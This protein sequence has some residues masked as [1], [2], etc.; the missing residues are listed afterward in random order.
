MKKIE[1][2]GIF[3]VALI[4]TCCF[5][6]NSQALLPTYSDNVLTSSEHI[7]YV[8]TN[9]ETE[10]LEA[11]LESGT[12][13]G[14]SKKVKHF[15]EN[16]PWGIGM[17]LTAMSVVFVGLLLL[18]VIFKQV[19]KTAVSISRRKAVKASGGDRSSGSGELVSGAVVAAI[20]AAL[21]EM[22]EDVHDWENTVLTI[23]KVTRNYSPWSSKI[24]ELR[25]TPQR[26]ANSTKRSN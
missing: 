20:S 25:E 26:I 15:Q 5:K 9:Q 22:N 12:K 2:T 1:K 6:A 7:S 13:S 3:I 11:T 8:Q 16:D 10:G 23:Q 14:L 4:L 21:Y 17:T 24:Y 19:G 18:F